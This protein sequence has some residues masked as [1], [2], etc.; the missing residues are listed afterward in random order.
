[1]SDP[2]PQDFLSWERGAA[3]VAAFSA[4]A[5][6][7]ETLVKVELVVTSP[8]ELSDLTRNLAD[9]KAVGET[10]P[11]RRKRVDTDTRP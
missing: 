4:V 9:L 3:R 10:T 7:G 2:R 1:M 5:R 8:W 6:K 11:A